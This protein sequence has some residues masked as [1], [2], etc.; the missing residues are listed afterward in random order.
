M[1][2][3]FSVPELVSLLSRGKSFV[4]NIASG[5][6]PIKSEPLSLACGPAP[7]PCPVP[8][9][10]QPPRGHMRAC[11]HTHTHTHTHTQ[12]P[13]SVPVPAPLL[14]SSLPLQL[15]FLP[16]LFLNIYLS[17]VALRFPLP[18]RPPH[19]RQPTLTSL[20]WGRSPQHVLLTRLCST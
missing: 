20:F 14:T 4:T 8:P 5:F 16:L 19:P 7:A 18:G 9:G 13:T 11:T 17:Q 15:S 10:I 12:D 6:L 2:T 1:A 3:Q